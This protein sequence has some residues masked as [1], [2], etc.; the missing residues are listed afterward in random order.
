MKILVTG[1]T[2]RMVN[3][4]RVQMD[5]ITFSYLLVSILRDMGH[6]V[7][8]RK[9]AIG[10][11][12]RYEYN[13][14]FCGVAPLSSMTSGHI[15]E[16]HYVMDQLPGR[17]SI[18][19]DDWSFCGFGKS[20]EYALRDWDRFCKYKNFSYDSSI[21]D[22]TRN[23][24]KSMLSMNILTAGNNAS[25]LAPMFPWGDHQFLMR[26]NYNAPLITVDPSAWVK[27]PSVKVPTLK[28]K[29][30]QWIMAALSNHTKWV[31]KQGF[32]LPVLYVGNKRME[33]TQ[34]LSEAA[35]VQ[36]F[37]DSFGVLST[38]YPS[39]GSGWWRTRYLNAGWAES[40]VYSDPRDACNMGRA[41]WG[42]PWQFE[43]LAGT[44]GYAVKVSEQLDWLN[45]N[46][47]KKDDVLTVMERLLS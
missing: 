21:T 32:K 3:S 18:Y 19:A 38:G 42:A 17:H 11:K 2:T 44:P 40:I 5:Y 29:K 43:Q 6:T 1:Y 20:I 28:N 27:Y 34:V 47:A 36:L 31:D 12:I 30:P 16:T 9:V 33:N 4:P 41:Y 10:E 25:V 26:D 13:F 46:V 8:H 23:S 39:A 7:E 35:T 24:L 45:K 37:A 14:A 15:C 22:D